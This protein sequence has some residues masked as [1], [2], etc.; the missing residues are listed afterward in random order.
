MIMWFIQG[1]ESTAKNI[2]IWSKNLAMTISKGYQ[3][4]EFIVHAFSFFRFP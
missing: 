1:N 3:N 2:L 4:E